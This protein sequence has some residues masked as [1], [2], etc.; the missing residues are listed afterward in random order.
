MR[1]GQWQAFYLL[2]AL[3]AAGEPAALLA[4]AGSPLL[5]RARANGIDARPLRIRELWPLARG[6]D[7]VHA[8]DARAHMLCSILKRPL[9]VSRRV[10]FPVKTSAAS[11][12]K[13]RR[14]M[15]YIAVSKFVKGLLLRA[16]IPDETVDVV[17]DG[18]PLPPPPIYKGRSRVVALDSADPGK[19]KDLIVEAAQRAGVEISFAVDFAG[20][21]LASAALFVYITESEGLGSAALLAMAAGVPVLASN[22]GGLPEI[23]RDG[24]TGVLTS[25]SAQQIAD[26]MGKLV[27]DPALLER[28]GRNA[29]AGVE[30]EF[31]TEHMA[32]QTMRVYEKVLA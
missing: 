17:Y 27:H 22:V 23:V 9:V 31:T 7:L 3:Q 32:A 28:L 10:A 2:R 16:G 6:F 30:Q 25:N 14:A 13:Y 1:G 5:E 11:R 18:V 24:V 20:G 21:F 15:R 29:R 4:P 26:N 19:G 8:H 12:W